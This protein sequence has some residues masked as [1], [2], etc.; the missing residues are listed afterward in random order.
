MARRL[1]TFT[2]A[3]MALTFSAFGKAQPPPN[4]SGLWQKTSESGQPVA[5]FLF[6]EHNGVYEGAIAKMF[7]RPNDPPP[8]IC[9]KCSDDRRNAPLLG[10]AL[11]RGMKRDG[12]SYDEG[13]IL[14]PRDG[15]IYRA[16]MTLSPDGRTLTV[17]GFLG[18]PLLGKDEV[19]RRLPNEAMSR[20]SPG[21]LAKYL[22]HV[23]NDK[24]TGLAASGS[25][26]RHQEPRR[27]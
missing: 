4:V 20:L 13:T 22:P 19:W 7:P 5:W 1:L 18:I 14:D 15:T 3:T 10:M 9:D 24:N 21:V 6:V 2:L 12:L 11:I 23:L 26:G 16:Q 17:R 8:S 25:D 27:E